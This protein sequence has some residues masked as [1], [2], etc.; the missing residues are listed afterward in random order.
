[1][2]KYM[3][4]QN[5]KYKGFLTFFFFTFQVI[6]FSQHYLLQITL[7]DSGIDCPTWYVGIPR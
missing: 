2:Y 1:M 4:K 3:K 6:H 7:H 5:H